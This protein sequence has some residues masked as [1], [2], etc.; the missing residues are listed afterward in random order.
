M[1]FQMTAESSW[2]GVPS[3]SCHLSAP[4]RSAHSLTVFLN[5]LDIAECTT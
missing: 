5:T 3:D 1:S 4:E 2:A